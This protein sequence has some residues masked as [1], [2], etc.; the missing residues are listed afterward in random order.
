[1]IYIPLISKKPPWMDM[2]KIW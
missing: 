1:L 2:H